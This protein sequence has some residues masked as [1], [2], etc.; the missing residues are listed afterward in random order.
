[1]KFAIP[2]ETT[3]M[4]GR[5]THRIGIGALLVL[6]ALPIHNASAQTGF[7]YTGRLVI[8]GV[9]ANGNYDFRFT[10][11][12][13]PT[14]GAQVG[15]SLTRSGVPVASGKYTVTLDF[16]TDSF[17][18]APL[19]VQIAYRKSGTSN[20][21]K[22][23]AGRL[24]LTVRFSIVASDTLALQGTP[25]SPTPPTNGQVLK[26]DGTQWKPGP[27]AGGASYS[28]G[29]GLQLVGSVFSIATGGV[30][31][32]MLANRAVTGEK[33]ALPWNVGGPSSAPLIALTNTGSGEGL[34]GFSVH[35]S[36]VFGHS[37]TNIG[38]RGL[39]FKNTGVYGFSEN[40]TGVDGH[41]TNATGVFGHSD[42]G[43][44][45]HGFSR[46]NV[47][48][49][50]ISDSLDGV[51]GHTNAV[52]R[53]GVHGRTDTDGWGVSGYSGA[54]FAGV[55]GW[56][57]RNG[58]SGFTSSQ[59]DSGVY[60]QNDGW[61]YGVA[62]SSNHTGVLGQSWGG[63]IDG[64]LAETPKGV[65]GANYANGYGVLGTGVDGSGVLGYS[66]NSWAGFFLGKAKVTGYFESPD[67]HFKIDHPLDPTNRYLVHACVESSERKNL[68][69]GNVTTDA[70]GD[71]E[72]LLPEWFE[73][74]NTDFR[75]QLTVIGQFAQAIVATEIAGGR[76]T[77][78]TDRPF[79]KVSWQVTGVRKDAYARAHPLEVE[80]EKPE[81]ERGKYQNPVEH[82]Q[83]ERMGILYLD[84]QQAMKRMPDRLRKQALPAPS[85]EN[86]R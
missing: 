47:G 26:F 70:N 4:C 66:R 30:V 22:N 23:I 50:G 13:A 41:S 5:W 58:V 81:G 85:K 17:A 1:M 71:A 54:G 20:A 63:T 37:D 76:F 75:Y 24:L 45:A 65:W 68:Y 51:L 86:R 83:P 80:P 8:S 32:S 82:G 14:A 6:L 49:A 28:A 2:E 27:D 42:N 16:G 73:A 69:D 61:G 18:D 59:W 43:W 52:G 67:K 12:N 3:T 64:N 7:S 46:S 29:A 77:I 53:S 48:V 10:L 44:G 39:S 78:K 56:G 62:G 57:G 74:L 19:Y 33:I 38:V 79:V 84:W 15:A 9:P 72:V 60:G 35:A 11:F 55:L 21:Y 25:V 40:G 34:Y 36:G 31:T